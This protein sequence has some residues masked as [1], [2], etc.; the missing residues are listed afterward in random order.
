[1]LQLRTE[2]R[3]N[4]D[5]VQKCQEFLS[6]KYEEMK[7]KCKEAHEDNVL[8]VEEKL[9]MIHCDLDYLHNKLHSLE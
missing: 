9:S 4:L 7:K 8:I 5:C 2:L 3:K 6:E 1:M